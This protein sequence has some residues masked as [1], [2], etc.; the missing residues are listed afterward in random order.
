MMLTTPL[1]GGTKVDA[2]QLNIQI[3]EPI[4]RLRRDNSKQSSTAAA[5]NVINRFDRKVRSRYLKNRKSAQQQGCPSV[6]QTDDAQ[7]D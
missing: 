3:L 6:Q 2:F 7:Y 4:A 5:Q 1:Q